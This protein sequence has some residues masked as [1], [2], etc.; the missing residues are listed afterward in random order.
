M[1]GATSWKNLFL[2]EYQQL[3]E[4]GYP[5]GDAPAEQS[6]YIPI[7]SRSQESGLKDE[8]CWQAAYEKLWAVREKGLRPDYPY[9]EPDD[10]D[11]IFAAQAASAPSVF[12]QE[13]NYEQRLQGA[14]YGRCAAV[15]LG[16]P[17]E[18]GFDNQKIREY[19]ESVDAYPLNDWVPEYS[20]SLNLRLREDCIPSTRGH[21]AYVQPDDDIH[22]TILSLLLAEKHGLDFTLE[23]LGNR[24]LDQV[25]YHWLWCSSRQAY[26]HLVRLSETADLPRLLPEIRLMQ[27]PFRECI[28]GQISADFW[29]YISPGDPRRAALLARNA[30]R[31]TLTK[32]G[33]YG[34]MFVA[35]CISA[36][37]GENVSVDQILDA[38]L[39][40]V[41][42]RSRLAEAVFFVRRHYA[43]THDWEETCR[44]I[45][46]RYGH[47][48]FGGTVN[49]LSFVV[50]SLLHGELD[51]TRTITTAVLCGTD[52]DCNAGTA[53]SIV[54]AAAGR[55]AIDPRWTEPLHDTVRTAVADFGCGTIS[56]LIAR[57]RRVWLHTKLDPVRPL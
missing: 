18:M 10:V 55:S 57:T 53:G 42:A 4:E 23:D 11:Q 6:R 24:L 50:L 2:E 28:D 37:F 13:K 27:N 40:V 7:A 46:E 8:S 48:P 44:A 5:V 26:Y 32:N 45:Y 36:A 1:P 31:L 15:L 47:L 25:P 14:W 52:T 34:A 3:R 29:G 16:K 33:L 35:A 9:V 30:N 43:G 39:S 19:L 49:N 54:G 51:Y 12:F 38:G 41:P 17:L 22:Y 20:P 56:D 21:V